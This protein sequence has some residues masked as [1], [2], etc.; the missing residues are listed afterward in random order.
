MQ[1]NADMDPS[2]RGKRTQ[3][4]NYRF[5]RFLRCCRLVAALQ[6]RAGVLVIRFF[7]THAEYDR[8]DAET[9]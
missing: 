3:S 6:Y 2:Y 5:R 1:A 8:I 9:L 4:M 7:G